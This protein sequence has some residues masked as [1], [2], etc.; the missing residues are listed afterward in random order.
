MLFLQEAILA[1][2]GFLPCVLEK[3]YSVGKD[4]SGSFIFKK[5]ISNTIDLL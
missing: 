5:K 3:K 4:V 1:K 2:F